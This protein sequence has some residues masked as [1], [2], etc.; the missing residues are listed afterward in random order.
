ME[1][2]SFQAKVAAVTVTPGMGW[3]KSTAAV[4]MLPEPPCWRRAVW[5]SLLARLWTDDA[6]NHWCTWK[7]NLAVA[8]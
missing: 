4:N 5:D 2:H 6:P 8:Y 7:A 1:Q 3:N